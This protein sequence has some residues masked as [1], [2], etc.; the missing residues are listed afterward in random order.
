MSEPVIRCR[1]LYKI[2]GLRAADLRTD[3][4]GVVEPAILERDGLVAAVNNVTLDVSPGEILI[5][6]GLSG[7][8]KSTL[9]RCLSRLIE[10]TSGSIEIEGADLLGMSEK[11]L[12]GLRRSKMGMVFQNFALL[13]HRTALENI[14]FPLQMRGMKRRDYVERARKMIALVGLEGR[15]NNFPREL[16]GGQ[17]QRVGIARSLAVEPDIWFLDEPFSALDP[18]IRKEMQDEFL[19]LQS[20]LNKTIVFITHDFDEALKLADR[21]AIM[22]DGGIEQ[23]G[24]PEDIVLEPATEYVS[25]FTSDVPREKVLRVGSVMDPPSDDEQVADRAV[26]VSDRIENVVEYVLG[27]RLPVPVVDAGDTVVGVMHQAHV[28]KVLFPA[29]AERTRDRL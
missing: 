27:E 10:P 15:E 29:R 24:K 4:E 1:S 5:V 19:R 9:V 22:F 21:I 18:L 23:I 3:D 11:E 28:L 8:G 12:I 13:P 17:Q 7:S 16:S 14:A 2:F 26:N 6:M 20:L 25:K